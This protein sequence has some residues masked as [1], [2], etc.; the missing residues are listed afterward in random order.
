ML[1]IRRQTKIT[2]QIRFTPLIDCV[3]LLL[4]FFML[5]TNF[6]SEEG[7]EVS[8]P[9]AASQMPSQVKEVHLK[10]SIDGRIFNKGRELNWRQ[11]REFLEEAYKANNEVSFI[12]EADRDSRLKTTVTLMDVAKIIGIKNIFIATQRL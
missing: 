7:I 3:F 1:K 11:A 9:K 2:P 6:I 12:I 8:L 5:T 10:V 4:I